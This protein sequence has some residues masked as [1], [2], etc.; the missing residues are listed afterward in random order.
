VAKF[1]DGLIGQHLSFYQ[2]RNQ[3]LPPK[4]GG[5]K[6]GP[7]NFFWGPL[8]GKKSPGEIFLKKNKPTKG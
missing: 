8:G 4:K 3:I 6:P 1:T 7:K 2:I 5:G